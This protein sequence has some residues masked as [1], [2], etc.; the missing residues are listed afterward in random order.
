M[1]RSAFL[2]GVS[3]AL[4]ALGACNSE[5]GGNASGADTSEAA[6]DGT[7]S[8]T[9]AAGLPA[10]GKF[11]TAAKAAGL[12]QTL[13]GSDSYT[14]LV[15][16]D[17]A[18]AKLPAGTLDNPANP[19]A[20]AQLTQILTYHILP[21]VVLADDIGKAIDNSKGKAVLATMG[22]GTL[23]ATREGGKVVFTD[24]KGQKATV[25]QADQKYSNGVVHQIDS[26]LAPPQN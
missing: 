13:A 11:M 6:K 7:A 5:G 9:I 19:Q 22:G 26:V 16:T 18:F 12:D 20:R 3:M 10:D 24:S 17:A 23:A 1:H 25:G 21:G 4:A 2:L 15:P 8:K 14:V